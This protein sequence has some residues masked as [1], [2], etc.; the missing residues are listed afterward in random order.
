MHHSR[1]CLRTT[2]EMRYT[3]LSASKSAVKMSHSQI[4]PKHIA[5]V[6]NDYTVAS[7]PTLVHVLQ[8]KNDYTQHNI[9][10]A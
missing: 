3:K 10:G 6:P 7:S 2:S 5:Y 4:C 8:Y 1:K 9:C